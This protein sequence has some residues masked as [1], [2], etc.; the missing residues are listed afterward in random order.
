M[1][2]LQKAS[3]YT[4]RMRQKL[5]KTL[6][7]RSG[8]VA[9]FV[10]YPLP[11]SEP[12]RQVVLHLGRSG[13]LGD[14][15]MCTPA[16]RELK[17]LNPACSIRFYTNYQSVVCNLPYID[18]VLPFDDRP[19]N[20]IFLGYE[21]ALPP[22]AHL[23]KIIGDHIGLE[24]RDVHPDCN[25]QSPLLNLFRERWRHFPQP[26][27]ALQR[28]ASRWTP[29]KDWP[30]EYWIELIERLVLWA[31]VVE[32]GELKSDQSSIQSTSNSNYIDLRGR[33]SVEELVAAIA[34][35]TIL[36]GPISGPIHIAAAVGIPSVVIYGGYEHPMTTAYERNV[37]LYTQV[38]CAPCW[39]RTP[40]PFNRKCLTA[41]SPN[42]VESAVR[43]V[44]TS[45]RT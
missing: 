32:I 25:V 41:I 19:D 26:I 18:R 20:A 2:L 15:L 13:G 29:N 16:L 28:Y 27:I 7:S 33:T 35:S 38:A 31:T 12:W 14:V 40:C 45:S 23:A 21:D 30:D 34:A 4:L 9:R 11:R 3:R 22:H 5:R 17:R 6:L 24:V 36:I 8:T 43:R 42:D 39:L 10:R 1:T 37:N 44:H